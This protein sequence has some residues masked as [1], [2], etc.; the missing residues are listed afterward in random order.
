MSVASILSEL[1]QQAGAARRA[2]GAILGDTIS[3]LASVPGQIMA[4]RDRA[5]QQARQ[6]A[7]ENEQ[8]QMRRDAALRQKAED[9]RR[10]AAD[11]AA[12][13]KS[14]ADA[15][16]E[17]AV[18]AGL[19]AATG[20]GTDPY[21]FDATAAF[22]KVQELGKPE[23]IRDVIKK[24]RE[25]AEPAPKLTEHDPA[26]E[27]RNDKG[28]VIAPAVPVTPRVTYGQPITAVVN[29]KRTLIREGSD[30]KTYGLTGE[31]IDGN[32]IAPESKE[33]KADEPLVAIIGP[34]GKSILVPRSQAVNK[35]PA[36]NREQGRP[37]TSGD[38]GRIADVDTATDQ[39]QALKDGVS[40]TTGPGS[41]L[42]THIPNF[43]TAWTGL[44][45]D[46]KGRQAM[47]DLVKQVIGKGLEG[48]VLR[49]EDEEKYKNILP[50]IGDAPEVV[51]SKITNLEREL[52]TKR[53]NVL[54]AL[55][56]A[57]YDVSKFRARGGTPTAPAAVA[58]KFRFNPASGK[59]EPIG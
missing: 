31:V 24:H 23:A 29:G 11:V 26:K 13:K 34:D 42:A 38:A 2:K 30:G 47:I 50:L 28:E 58:P 46:S 19:L 7:N 41:E 39:L 56:D 35:R 1:A 15:E 36:S 52:E 33:P 55:E 21:K 37:V 8:M 54:N 20:D 14:A 4:D 6:Q 9:D 40:G 16:Y 27:L 59:V 25:I 17:S 49:K 18:N 12:G 48:G 3:S 10:A 45:A 22:A 44:G 57:N 53:E 5:S 32:S 43:V 51:A